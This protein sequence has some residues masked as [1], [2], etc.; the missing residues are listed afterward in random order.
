M[1]TK[2]VSL[3]ISVTLILSLFLTNCVTNKRGGVSYEVAPS[4]ELTYSTP[5][6]PI[7]ISFDLLTYKISV[8]INRK[9]Q[10]P[11]GTFGMSIKPSRMEKQIENRFGGVRILI[12]AAGDQRYVY[13]LEKGRPYRISLP[14]DENGKTEV[15]YT[16][17]DEDL[18]ITIPNPTSETMAELRQK[19]KDA[20][21]ARESA[22]AEYKALLEGQMGGERGNNAVPDNSTPLTAQT[23]DPSPMEYQPFTREEC[24]KKVAEYRPNKFFLVPLE[25]KDILE[26]YKRRLQQQEYESAPT[27]QEQETTRQEME[28]D[29]LERRTEK[30][31]RKAEATARKERIILKTIEEGSK[32]LV[33]VFRGRGN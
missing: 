5:L 16:G 12:I 29:E 25:C 21:D 9:I 30:A 8:T 13:E 20:E 31:R 2:R 11:L 15:S 22:E 7:Q 1:N 4:A 33:E 19:L 14:T 17:I 6:L 28:A 23:P 27:E 24:E 26:D 18:Q 10:T 3:H 32:V